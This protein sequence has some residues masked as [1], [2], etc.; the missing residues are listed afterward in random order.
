MYRISPT[1]KQLLIINVIFFIGTMSLPEIKDYLSLFFPEN[2]S[3][4]FWQVFTHMFMHANLSHLFFNMFALWMFGSAVES[5]LGSRKFLF[6]YVTC[7]LGAAIIQITYQYYNVY[8]TIEMLGNFEDVLNIL[9]KNADKYRFG[10]I[11]RSTNEILDNWASNIEVDSVKSLMTT[12]SY[13]MVGASGAIMGVLVAFGMFFPENKLML[14]FLPIP[15]K[16]KYFIPGIILM[17][18]FSAITGTAIFSP[19]NTAF[20]AHIGG[21]LTG[22]LLMYYWKKTQFNRNR[23]Y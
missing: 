23:W 7:G 19:S 13:P 18:L 1:V 8:S 4:W 15:I 17:D 9:N 6:F 11:D 20:V 10:I 5:M 16:A 21:A 3:F 14:I 2:D 22:F 12:F